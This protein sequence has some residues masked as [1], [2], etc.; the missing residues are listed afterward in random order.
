MSAAA[1]ANARK[2]LVRASKA[3]DQ[4]RVATDDWH[5]D[6][7]E[8]AWS[9]FLIAASDIYEKLRQGVKGHTKAAPWFGI[10]V[11]VR[12][13]DALLSYLQHA[14]NCEHH[15]IEDSTEQH[16]NME[17]W[18]LLPDVKIVRDES[19]S[20]VQTLF[21]AHLLPGDG[22]VK[23]LPPGGRL[24]P[25]T[26][27]RGVAVPPP[28]TFLGQHLMDGSPLGLADATLPYLEAIIDEAEHHL[29]R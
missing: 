26:D 11:N 3:V 8:E 1:I 13:T 4:L 12:K 14:R 2:R 23:L 19:G 21:P 29:S 27:R 7:I 17:L 5:Y 10:V 25:V 20:I 18:P 24:V 6:Q 9:A 28:R 15:G 16:N 22:I